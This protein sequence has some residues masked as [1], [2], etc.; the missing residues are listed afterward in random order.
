MASIPAYRGTATVVF[1]RNGVIRFPALANAIDLVLGYAAGAATT[2]VPVGAW[3]AIRLFPQGLPPIE[4]FLQKINDFMRA[5][6]D[7]LQG[8]ID[9]ILA[10]I[11]FIEARIL[12]IEALLRRI[13]ALID[14]ALSFDIGVGVSGLLVTSNGTDGLVRDFVNASNTPDSGQ[15]DIGIGFAIV[16]GGIPAFLFDILLAFFPEA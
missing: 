5:V 8:I 2:P 1:I 15:N 10:Y 4:E 9:A 16:S 13:D 11:N 7:G 14:L 6:L 3:T 12:E